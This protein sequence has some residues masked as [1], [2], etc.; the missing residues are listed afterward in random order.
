MSRPRDQ[1]GMVIVIWHVHM[2]CVQGHQGVIIPSCIILLTLSAHG[3]HVF[4][5]Q[6]S[7]H[8]EL[9]RTRGK[10]ISQIIIVWIVSR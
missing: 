6:L 8:R 1:L 4:W 2:I 3:K 10:A 9:L 7:L 5:D